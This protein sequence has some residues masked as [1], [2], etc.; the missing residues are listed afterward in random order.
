MHLLEEL[1][2]FGRRAVDSFS[3]RR[4][5]SFPGVLFLHRRLS[6][7]L[8]NES[9]LVVK[10]DGHRFYAAARDLNITDGLVRSGSLD[11]ERL[12]AKLIKDALRP[13]MT[14]LDIGANV[15]YY[16]LMI[17]RGLQDSGQVYAFEP[18]PF[19]FRLLAAN[20]KT[21]GYTNVTLV[22]KAVCEVDG[23]V[24]VF[25]DADRHGAHSLWLNNITQLSS[26]ERVSAI[27]LD[28]FSESVERVDLIKMDIQGA[29]GGAIRGGER[30]LSEQ[31]PILFFEIS[32]CLL[33]HA[34]DDLQSI[35]DLLQSWGYELSVINEKRQTLEILDVGK[36]ESQY[37]NLYDC[38]NVMAKLTQ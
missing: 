20:V 13:S 19:N 27:T 6:R 16:T 7:V 4:P 28:S 24:N 35:V 11:Y 36:L 25:K 15:G 18:E 33:R 1:A 32:P 8:G 38:V 34:G 37:K 26:V 3:D 21:N 17:A 23:E 12:Q 30:L 10:A 2:S 22:R 14:V 9:V 5:W 29:E 31:H